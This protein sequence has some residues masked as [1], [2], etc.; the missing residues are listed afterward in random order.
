[1]SGVMDIEAYRR[2]GFTVVEGM[3]TADK[4]ESF[5]AYMMDLQAGRITVEGYAP[6]DP[7]DRSG[8]ISSAG[9]PASLAWM[10]DP[11]LRQALRTFLGGEPDG[12][13]R[14]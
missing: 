13:Q 11:R 12:V 3:F 8:L 1:M 14:M 4:C 9:T 6:R 10:I 2:D 5:L 7:D